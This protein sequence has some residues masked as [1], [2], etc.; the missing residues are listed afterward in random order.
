MNLLLITA[1]LFVFTAGIGIGIYMLTQTKERRDRYMSV[2]SGDKSSWGMEDAKERKL[3][4]QRAEIARKLKEAGMEGNAHG[5]VS[6]KLR[7]AQA[8]IDIPVSRFWML[9][10]AFGF[11]VWLLV[12]MTGLSQIVKVLVIFTGFIGMPRFF[13]N[14]RTNRRQKKFMD[15]F[16]DALDGM[17]RLLQSGI[18]MSEAVAMGAREFKGPIREE[19]TMVYENQKIGIPL[20][21]AALLMAKRVPLPEVHMFATAL[22]IQSETGSSLSEVLENLSGVIRARYRLRRKIRAVSSE[23]KSSA[24]IIAALP[25]LVTVGLYLVRPEYIG[26]LFE[27]PKGKV[28]V[29]G[30]G[31]WMSLGIL[32]MR[33]MINFKI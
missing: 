3:S 4:K 22:H 6:M 32:V 10:I 27:D 14:F 2:I 30:A 12:S 21:E 18:P 16:A 5:K 1:V 25:I 31:I 23:A 9:S 24:A 13:L 15:D 26:V 28:M 17:G 20:G 29:S 7:L 33:Q 11:L 19:L 8:G